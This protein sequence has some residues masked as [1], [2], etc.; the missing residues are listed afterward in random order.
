MMERR[1]LMAGGLAAGI[2]ALMTPDTAA[3][4]EAAAQRDSDDETV[5]RAVNGLRDSLD[6]RLETLQN[7][8]WRRV[9]QIR[10]QQRL[11][12]RSTQ[13]YP[14]FIEIGVDVWESLYDWHIRYQQPLNVARMPDGRYAMVFMFTTLLLRSDTSPDFVGVAFDADVRRP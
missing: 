14:D 4:A 3:G 1:N 8:A 11:W 5:A 2:T 7:G 10:E 13:K 6:R 12:L 9:T